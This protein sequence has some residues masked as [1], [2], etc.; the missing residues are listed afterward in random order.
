MGKFSS[1]EIESQYLLIKMLLAE[2]EKYMDAINA[3]K[4]DI[5]Y[6]PLELKK[7]LEEENILFMQTYIVHWQFPDQESHMQGA[8]AFAGFVEGGCEGDEFD[9]FKVLNRVVN[10]EGANGW[11]I[12]ESSNHQNIWKWS[13]IWADNF[14]VE[15][16][17]TPVLTDKEFLSVHKE[18]AAAS[19]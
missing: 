16:E 18:I 10:P 2:P 15:I 1:E 19:N 13:S 8:E 5:A 6:M 11:A 17:V 4:K 14:G 3:I 7:K 9:G 12:V